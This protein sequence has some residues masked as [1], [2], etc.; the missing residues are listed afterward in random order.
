[1]PS[2]TIGRHGRAASLIEIASFRAAVQPD[3]Q[4]YFFLKDGLTVDGSL[5]YG[6]LDRQ[7]RA[8]A[9]FLQSRV[10]VGARIL[11]LYPPGLDF[12]RAFWGCLY[13]GMLAVPAAPLDP[14]RIKTRLPQIRAIARDAQAACILT[15]S[16]TVA[17]T[18]PAT[19]SRAEG[20]AALWLTCEEIEEGWGEEWKEPGVSPDHVAY[21]QYTSGSTADPKG[22]MVTHGNLIHHG[23]YITEF[24]YYDSDSATLSWMPHFH[25]YGLVKGILQP[26]FAGIPAY[27]MPALIFLKRPVRWLQAIGR[28]GITHSGGPN[29]AYAHCVHSTTM[30]ERRDLNLA[31]WRLASCG[32]EPISR[33]TIESFVEAFEPV[34]FRREAFFPAYGMAEF[35][36]LVSVKRKGIAPGIRNLD[37]EALQDGFVKIR[38]IGE[39]GMRPV[40]SCGHPVGDTKVVIVDPTTRR[41]C[42]PETVGEIWLTGASVA[43]GYWN[44]SEETTKTF[45][46]YLAETGAGPYLRTGDLGFV[47][48]GELFV[49]GR[50]KDLIIIR[51]RNHYPQ[52]IEQTV[53]QCHPAVRSGFGAAF[54]IE[55]HNEERLVVVQELERREQTTD[56]EEVAGT[57]RRAVSEHHDLQVYA[58]VLIRA[59]SIPK[60]TSGK[61]RRG[62][63]R[64]GFLSSRLESV[65]TSV[66]PDDSVDQ[67]DEGVTR[68]GLLALTD[69]ER[70]AVLVA[71]LERLVSTRLHVPLNRL[72]AD[73][74]LS[75][76]GLDSLTAA[77]LVH[78]CEES[79][80][81]SLPLA[82]LL[83]GATIREVVRRLLDSAG[84]A[85]FCPERIRTGGSDVLEYPLSHNQ[86]ALWFLH[87]LA[88]ESAAANAALL[89][90]VTGGLDVKALRQALRMLSARHAALRTT[91]PSTGGSPVQRVHP[92]FPV[93][94]EEIN[95]SSWEW[96]ELRTQCAKAAAVPFD[97]TRGPVWRAHLYWRS[98]S[99]AT[100]LLVAHHIVVDGWSMTVLVEDLRHAYRAALREETVP[101]A[102]P[103]AQY[104][105]FVDWQ[106]DLLSGVEGR[107]LLAYWREK[108]SGQLPVLDLPHDKPRPPLQRDNGAWETFTV[109][110]AL[111]RRLRVLAKKEGVTLYA[112]LVAALQVLLY[113]YTGQEVILVG[114]PMFGRSRARFAKTVGDFVN[115]VVLRESLSGDATFEEHLSRTRRTV[116]EAMAHQ[117]YP[118]SLLV[119]QLQPARDLSRA[120]L[121]QVLFALQPFT[122]FTEGT[123]AFS[124]AG[125]E[126]GDAPGE[127]RFEPFVI[128]QQTGQFDLTIEVADVGSGLTGYFEYNADLFEGATIR[129]MQDHFLVL[130]KGIVERPDQRLADLPILTAEE[131]RQVSFVPTETRMSDSEMP[132]LHDLI[133]AQARR[134]PNAVAVIAEN[135]ELTYHELC[136]RANQLGH[137]LQRLGVG[138]D[139]LVGLCTERSPDLIVALL[140]I[141]KAG[142]AYVPLDPEYPKQRLAAMLDDAEVPILLT[143][144]HLLA[145]LPEHR[146]RAISLDTEWSTIAQ[147]SPEPP[148]DGV[149]SSNLAYVIYTSGSAGQPKGVMVEHRAVV[150][151][152]EAVAVEL[153]LVPG[154]RI[155][156]LASI[157]FDTAVE[158]IFSCLT[159]GA[160]L[161]LR[162]KSMLDSVPSFLQKCH[163]W[164]ITLLDIPT[165]YWHELTVRIEAESLELPLAVRAVVIGGERA[166]RQSLL[167]WQRHVG[168]RV[169]LLNTYGPTEVTVAA[170]ICDLSSAESYAA[171]WREVSIGRAIQNVQVYVLDRNMQ[172]V[173]VGTPGELCVGGVGLARG[174]LKRPHL[175]AERF[176]ANPFSETPGARLY[177][178]GDVA[179]RL[180]DGRL[181][182][183][184]R[185]DRQVKIRGYR[186]E[187]EEIE[188]VLGTYP[189]LR[190][191]A[192]EV[193]EDLPGDKRL[194]AFIVAAPGS[195]VTVNGLRDYLKARLPVYMIP[196]TFVELDALPLTPNG[197]IDRKAFHAPL[198]S[199]ATIPRL[200]EK[201]V[202]PRTP[203][204]LLLAQIWGE[205]LEIKDLGIYDNFFELGGHSLLA[206]QMFSR[207]RSLLCAEPPLRAVFENPTIAGLAQWLD[208]AGPRASDRKSAPAIAP[209]SREGLLP[210]SFAQERMW[211]LH[212]LAPES[213][214]YNIPVGVRLSGPLDREALAFGINELVRRHESL[215]TTF[216]EVEGRPLQ[217]IHPFRPL[218]IREVDLAPYPKESREAETL[219]LMTEEARGP[220]DLTTGPLIRVLLVH[221]GEEDHVL[222]MTTH[223]II[224]DQWSYGVI[225][226][227]LVQCYNAFCGGQPRAVDPPLAIQYADFASWQRDW[228]RGQTLQDQCAYWK[229]RLADVPVLALPT[230][231]PRPP[232]HS[233]RGTYVFLDL[234]LPLLNG[235]KQLSTQ[236][237]ATLYMVFLAGFVTLLHRLTGQQDI[238]VGT[239]IANRGWLAVEGLI[240]TF[241]NTLVLRADVSGE[242]TFRTLL[243]RVRDTALDAFAHQDL[244]FEK[245]VEELRPDRSH[246]GP[247]LVQVLFNFANTPFGRVDFKHLSWAPY[248]IDR[249]AS[250]FDLSLSVD[251]TVLRRVVV[252]FNTDLFD[253]ASMERWLA[254]YVTLLEAVVDKPETPVS[255][256]RLLSETERR[257]ILVQW[258]DTR[259]SD[260]TDRCF[261][262]LF[263]DQVGRTP[264]R[265]AVES[266]GQALTYAALNR[267]A[268][269]VAHYLRQ[270]GIRPD[271]VVGIYMERSADLLVCLLGI[272]KAGA[273]YLPLAPGLPSKRMEYMLQN[274][275]AAFL[276]TE[277]RLANTVSASDVPSINVDRERESIADQSQENLPAQ[278]NPQHLAYV[279]YTSGSTGRP[280]GVEIEHRALSNF[281]QSMRREPGLTDRDVLL[282]VTTLSF[283][284]AGLELYLPLLVGASVI[285]ADQEQAA[286]G[287]WLRHQLEGTRVTAMQ[288]TPATWQMVLHAGWT[289]N[290]GLKIL[291]GGEAL[292]RE[293]ALDLL[294]RSGSVWNMYG[295]TETTIW[296]TT[297]RVTKEEGVISVGRPI[298][299]TQVYVLDGRLEPV[300]VGIPGELYIGGMG[301]A[302]GYRH[303]PELTAAQFL[304]SPFSGEKE[305]IY[306]TGDLARWL[307]DGRLDCLGRIDHQVKIRG[308]RIEL[309]EVESV[310]SDT[311]GV[312][313]CVVVARDEGS[314]NKR[315]VAYVVPENGAAPHPSQLRRRLREHLPEYMVPAAVVLLETLPLTP[316]G[317]IDRLA[318]PPPS[319]D[320]SEAMTGNVQPRDRMELQLAAIWEQ[321]LGVANVGVR[322]NFFDLGGH[323]FLALRIMSAIEQTLGTRFPMALLFRAPTIELLAEVLG[324][325]G[326]E[327]RWDS[328][329]AIQPGG[330]KPPF[331]AVPGVGGNVLM[332]ARLSQ[333]L[334]PDQPFYGLQARGLDGKERPFTDVRD[335]A[336]HYVQEV[337]SVQ[338]KGPYLI[339]GTCT[340]GVVAYEMAQQLSAQGERVILMIMESWHPRSHHAHRSRLQLLLWPAQFVVGKLMSYCRE[341]WALSYRE[342]PEYWRDKLAKFTGFFWQGVLREEEQEITAERVKAATFF[343][344]SR[345][346]PPPYRGRLL[347]I[348]ASKRA[349]SGSTEDTRGTWSELALMGAQTVSIP[350]EDSGRLFVSPHV[351]ELAQ[352]LRAHV[353][354]EC[355]E[356][357]NR[358]PLNGPVYVTKMAATTTEDSRRSLLLER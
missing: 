219:R 100:L 270:L 318:L 139:V 135:R 265:L 338:P 296:S 40:V 234:P 233:F 78:Q 97:L 255:R 239:P 83:D 21:L 190:E 179:R 313:Q 88:P 156:Q 267:R 333:L 37:A 227:E 246:G 216:R 154:D 126:S 273:A 257:Q 159:R 16:Q 249:G 290:A 47:Q 161:V 272:M 324:Q 212:L 298:A 80:G 134:T 254:H 31:S 157:S 129:R 278:A 288:A 101:L 297:Q 29:F 8:I 2:G 181:E 244:P 236:E 259:T 131:H 304:M 350:A 209:V 86:S 36:L 269:Q 59:G 284:I 141:L 293:L 355:P 230:D 42:P 202:A 130:L 331:F 292:S 334:G 247:P 25:D 226:R 301:L 124:G 312:K 38:S 62:A 138:P 314:G 335:M 280:K 207:V 186:V 187:L 54:S 245:L 347:N 282:A 271:D 189:D 194:V 133:E 264:A 122:L 69:D 56:T 137:Y 3:R 183:L 28:Y 145:Q 148:S 121:V 165:A 34:G 213:S 178:T 340:G 195:A 237:G 358:P 268:N 41:E 27:L 24:G 223:H 214:A 320:T 173:P 75:T 300:P 229:A 72:E 140:G 23:A 32:A 220:F 127:T 48:D 211:F 248:E 192:V 177:R 55:M 311:P 104:T 12:V 112:T 225:G 253:R 357:L 170:T 81:V 109:D 322:D 302:R 180:P 14:L 102:L 18:E 308:F 344:V 15:T 263:E 303:A 4:A 73:Q 9:G 20:D 76:L 316:S 174:Y 103:E 337:R 49:T 221:M 323:S 262:Q 240:G 201:Y 172:P 108:L 92:S 162:T 146:A 163:E 291:C 87:E 345:Y 330:T 61:I 1:M 125:G 13:A 289:G 196:S 327:V 215:R 99:A 329:V 5:T 356:Y 193:R 326:C 160:T 82:S 352:H 349:R 228:L 310:L 171:S 151:Y 266:R 53:G 205:I 169:R 286:D 164:G 319:E 176:V 328:L 210:A 17:K 46:A 11:L 70:Q 77:E 261:P 150:N 144:H 200:H 142:G 232:G 114:S 287:A 343:A 120:P 63:C 39:N 123:D 274:S 251:P 33:D 71:Y 118:F 67:D 275:G 250:Q 106:S 65:A 22:V 276:L 43:K 218:P 258:N 299:N 321:V 231:R 64:E 188:S 111:A 277:D 341:A 10:E 332:F 351:Q 295:P 158:E 283:D 348:I 167:A 339:G 44:R 26:A 184:G 305:R 256:L 243:S 128:P 203:T 217:V 113:R 117:D 208:T 336:A 115:I 199:R 52:D 30:E 281:L 325:E 222:S 155:L 93:Q 235:L 57:V 94:F 84:W 252:E 45:R 66:L 119:E 242:P 224:A 354:R 98:A 74:P 342:W 136:C 19:L 107:R 147:E 285:V 191:A 241:V 166:I 279:I 68:E 346:E 50:L 182:Y 168:S 90:N 35:T 116:L 307:P 60:T 206:T 149:T 79:L 238:A 51:G 204:E 91:F 260:P 153:H 353:S 309:G 89:L 185:I 143:Q 152:A 6:E 96:E 85:A 306:R 197:K 175:T 198:N 7:A 132:C 58:V 95:V 110:D 317:K 315:L 105:D 294:S